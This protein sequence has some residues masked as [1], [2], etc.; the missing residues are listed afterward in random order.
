MLLG[1]VC[2]VWKG[3]ES[4]RSKVDGFGRVH[5]IPR[6]S[7]VVVLLH[8]LG[9]P[10]ISMRALGVAARRRGFA[11]RNMGYPSLRGRIQ[12]HALRLSH[13]L[14]ELA[15]TPNIEVVHLVTH[16][17]GGIVARVSLASRHIPKLGRMVMMAPP[18][19][20][21]HVARLIAPNL[22]WLCK[23]LR[24]LSDQ[25][26]SYVNCLDDFR[27]LNNIQF[28]IIA[29]AYDAV[30]SPNS[31]RLEGQADHAVVNCRHGTLPWN[32]EA[33]ELAFNFLEYGRFRPW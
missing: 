29:A 2:N 15:A 30:V 31:V 32:Q 10:R 22:G 18:N 6:D 11:Y 8:G 19:A 26:S 7:Q 25:P 28:G 14:D 20:G 33:V 13:V 17:M 3:M 12:E 5:E 24:Q 21:S 23:P 16:S 9:A 27:T 1:Y 4:E